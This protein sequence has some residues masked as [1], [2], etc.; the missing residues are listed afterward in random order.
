MNVSSTWNFKLTTWH[1]TSLKKI[2]AG[3]GIFFENFENQLEIRV[4]NK[5]P[6]KQKIHP[7]KKIHLFEISSKNP[8]TVDCYLKISID[9]QNITWRFSRLQKLTWKNSWSTLGRWGFCLLTLF[10]VFFF[11]KRVW[12]RNI[13][14]LKNNCVYLFLNVLWYWLVGIFSWVCKVF[15]DFWQRCVRVAA[16]LPNVHIFFNILGSV[17]FMAGQPTAP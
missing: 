14:G 1:K 12:K 16:F 10:V 4:S 17:G 5:N 15:H 8:S 11:R 3:L 2:K 13:F 7:N 6:S 9:W